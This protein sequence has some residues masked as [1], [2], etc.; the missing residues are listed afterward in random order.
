MATNITD[1]TIEIVKELKPLTVP[2]SIIQGQIDDLDSNYG[3]CLVANY[4]QNDAL[5]KAVTAIGW[6]LSSYGSSSQGGA[7]KSMD[8][9]NGSS[10]EFSTDSKVGATYDLVDLNDTAGCLNAYIGIDAGAS[11]V[12]G[13]MKRVL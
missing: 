7:I 3:A 2:D 1:L 4:G 5:L 12:F 13:G 8:G 11:G 6:K 10:I 9:A